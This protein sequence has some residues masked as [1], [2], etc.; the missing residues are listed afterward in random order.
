M[1]SALTLRALA[2]ASI[3]AAAGWLISCRQ[4]SRPPE[5]TAAPAA[6]TA[7]AL[8]AA[9][10]FASHIAPIVFKNCAVCHRPGEA[11][12]FSLLTFAE[13]AKRSKLIA[14]VT[15]RRT[16]PPWLPVAGH[17]SFV[18]ERRLTATEIALFQRW[19]DQG[20]PEGDAAL[21]PPIPPFTDGW[22]LGPPDAV[23]TMPEPFAL[24]ADG[25]DVYRNFVLTVPPGPARFVR[26][27]EFRPG[28][29]RAVHHAF[30]L[31]DDQGD[32]VTLDDAAPGPGYPGMNAGPSARSP[33]GHFVSWQPG[34]TPSFVPEGMSW[35]LA[36]GA[37]LVV[38]MHLQP[39]GRPES[40][41][42][43]VGL[44][45]TTDPPRAV[46]Y[47][48][49]LASSQI[50]VPPGTAAHVVESS[51]RLPVDVHVL[52]L[53]PH[54]HYLGRTLHGT[55]ELPNGT[56]QWLMRID[57]WDFKWQGDYRYSQPVFL[58]KGTVLRQ[59]F[60]YDN[61]EA[62]PRN[63]FH[64][65]RR[66]TFGPNTTDEMGELWIQVLPA[67]RQDY[68]TLNRDYGQLA[69]TRRLDDMRRRVA[70][71]PNDAAVLTEY[72]KTLI[73]LNRAP[74]ATPHLQR[75]IELDDP[76][77]AEAWYLQGMIEV[78][79]GQPGS[80]Q[81]A[82]EKAISRQPRHFAAHNALGMLALRAQ[83]P[84]RALPHFQ[85]AVE[86]YPEQAATQANLGLTYLKLG[87]P[88]EAIAPLEAAL[89]LEPDNP[90]R[91]E[92]LDQARAALT[93]TATPP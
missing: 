74:E 35:R 5:T 7:E 87:R 75:A 24:P 22:Q 64:P 3:A 79:G 61:S 36:P 91:K 69:I 71:T 52:G 81:T 1:K 19:H 12:P 38:Q 32:S 86:A 4:E 2:L 55:A 89:S 21:T 17:G 10:T 23:V 49:V 53:I 8:P 57:D 25:R 45:F 84:D 56:R 16:M 37:R 20:A 18:G 54:A 6:A 30:V 66:I 76:N 59:H 85:S 43:S 26:G 82:F 14:E 9:P 67:S 50:D 68:E 63:P 44:F 11:G 70:D 13:V 31:V 83:S 58:P 42:A 65:P 29:P 62:N 73:A 47:K 88:A 28:N 46:P 72:A 92:M 40:V 41:Q 15:A 78:R 39:T 34:K 93:P 80:A 48:L 27:V 90:K 77:A 60:T 33:G 51:Y